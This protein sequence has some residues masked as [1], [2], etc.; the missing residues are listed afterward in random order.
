MRKSILI[1]AFIFCGNILH[2]QTNS[3]SL[4][5]SDEGIRLVVN[6]NDF[7]INGMNWDYFPIGTNFNLQFME[8]V[9]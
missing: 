3:V 1:I 4:K 8:S 7:I 9:Q 5:K 2:A 6:G